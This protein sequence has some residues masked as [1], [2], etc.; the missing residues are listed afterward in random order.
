MSIAISTSTDTLADRLER[1]GGVSPARI[2]M[3]P[4]PGTA[5]EEHVLTTR[6]GGEKRIYELVDGMLVEKGMGWYESHL[7]TIL[8]RYLDEYL[9]QHKVG[10]A[11]GE[12]GTMRLMPGLVRVPDVS[13]V[14]WEHFP[15]GT[16]PADPILDR[17]PDLAIEVLSKSN[18]PQEMARKRQEYFGAGC[19][20]V[21]VVDPRSRTA[22]VYTSPETWTEVSE[23]G[24]LDGGTVLPG[25]RLSMRHWFDRAAPI[26]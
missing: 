12:A 8:L 3:F 6:P 20:L 2:P 10:F 25:F 7:A 17:G 14:S 5:T 19:R 4:A 13:F 26:S 16:V 22:R 15:G 23:D 11:L 18:T 21:W 9:E 1:L 24:A